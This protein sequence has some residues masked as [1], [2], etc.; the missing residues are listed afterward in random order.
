M[1][2]RV[3]FGALTSKNLKLDDPKKL[4]R[5]DNTGLISITDLV[6]SL[7]SRVREL[8]SEEQEGGRVC[9]SMSEGAK[10]YFSL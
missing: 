5:A 7:E 3:G 10:Q 8:V 9:S 2:A 6:Y 1:R 4:A